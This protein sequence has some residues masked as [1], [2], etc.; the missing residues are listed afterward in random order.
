MTYKMVE[1]F[2]NE[3]N[4]DV[5][6]SGNGRWIDQKCAL[7]AVCFV[8]DCIVDYIRNGGKQPFQSPD[9]WRSE[10]AIANVQY[11]FGKPD[12]LTPTTLDEY[13]K[14]FRQPMKM[15]AAAGVLRE[16]GVV[17][18][19]IQFSVERIEVL[20]YI[21]LRERNSFDFLCL[22]IEKTLR[23]SG[24]WYSFETFFDEQTKFSLQELKNTF[25]N[26]CIRYTPINTEREANRIFVKV[27]NPLACRFHKKGAFRGRLSPSMMTYDKIMYNQT[28]W[29]DVAVGKDKNVAR[30]DFVPSS[31]N[32]QVYEYRVTR[33]KKYLRQFNDKY[34]EGKSEV[35]DKFSV[36]E[37][38]THMHHIFPKSQFEEIAD[39]IE[40]L[41]ALTSGQHLQAAHP[42]GNTSVVDPGYQ[43]T[44]LIA[45]TESIRRNILSNQGEP[46]IYNFDDFMY[47]LDIGLRTNYFRALPNCDFNAVLTGIEFN[48]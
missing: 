24:L 19:A 34:C 14:F 43:Y 15:L 31:E 20:E 33:A 28:N 23:D 1:A 39:Y 2:V 9:I 21:A 30:R 18:N 48:Y 13:N 3:H 6:I 16:D 5:R 38:A 44:C 7:D 40:N 8:A 47:V 25:S 17:N 22:Y 37:K 26:F 42:N 10:Y 46:V 11:I 4:Y 41:I 12:P 35:L 29:R 32:N 27:L 45:K 36:G